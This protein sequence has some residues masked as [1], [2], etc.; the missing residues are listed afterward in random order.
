MSLHEPL[1]TPTLVAVCVLMA[2]LAAAVNRV[3]LHGSPWAAPIA[4]LRAAAQLAAVSTVLTVALQQL[5]SS[6]VVLAVMFTVASFTAARRSQ[7]RHGAGWLAAALAAGMVTVIPLLL[8]TGIVPLAGVALVPVF[9]IV[10]GGTMTASAVAARRAL[11]T[12][13]ERHGEVE[14]ALSLGLSERFSRMMV[15]QRPL[16]DALI[17]N[18]D[19][20]RTAGLVTLPG[21]FVGVLLATGSAAQAGAV[22][23]LVVIAL[24]LAQVC[25]VA[26]VGELVARGS[27]TRSGPAPDQAR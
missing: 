18:L 12:L 5:W 17:P 16:S 21:A 9:G 11:D 8:L 27:I 2:L 3:V 15:I 24:L 25:G 7:A 19:Q 22:Q 1:L 10:L 23:V 14:A 26:V 4:A 6:L 20:A 13:G